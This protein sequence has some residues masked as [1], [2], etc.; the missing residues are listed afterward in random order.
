MQRNHSP[1]RALTVAVFLLVL[2]SSLHAAITVVPKPALDAAQQ[3]IVAHYAAVDP[4]NLDEARDEIAYIRSLT[5]PRE[6]FINN[7]ADDR[8][9]RF[10]LRN[11]KKA[12]RTPQ[13]APQLFATVAHQRARHKQ[14]PPL[15]AALVADPAPDDQ[16]ITL[17]T[18]ADLGAVANTPATYSTTG[19]S[20]V[21]GGT[22]STV[23]VVQLFDGSN[24]NPIGTG[25]S[26][27]QFGEGENLTTVQTSAAAQALSSV[28][29]YLQV[30]MQ[31]SVNADPVTVT[32]QTV[33]A[34][35]PVNPP[36]V[37]APIHVFQKPPNQY[38]TI[39]L[40]RKLKPDTNCDYGPFEKANANPIVQL[41]VSGSITYPAPI[42]TKRI[43]AGSLVIWGQN[44]GGACKVTLTPGAFAQAFTP[45]GNQLTWSFNNANFGLLNYNP[46]WQAGQPYGMMLDVYVPLVGTLPFQQFFV[47]TVPGP[48]LPNAKRIDPLT[49]TF[50]CFA[51]GTRVLMADG[52]IKAIEDIKAGD[53]VIADG[54]GRRLTVRETT[55]GLEF[56]PMVVIT[57]AAGHTLSITE[58]HAVVIQD[59]SRTR[60]VLAKELK[61]GDV[62]FTSDM[63]LENGR[64]R[65][66][67]PSRIV[68]I[69]RRKDDRHVYNV[70]LGV[71]E[72]G[73]RFGT[74][75]T[76]LIAD[77]I[78][79][80]DNAM[81]E[82]YGAAFNFKPK[83]VKTFL[84]R[85]WHRDYENH[86][87]EQKRRANTAGGK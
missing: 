17:N 71:R 21:P 32:V 65:N 15:S 79:T 75:D 68:K 20:T 84:P 59:G 78:L 34:V 62:V 44:G 55:A 85:E 38:I 49:F 39:C 52:S 36:D 81:Q 28:G 16:R 45:N 64:P 30:T 61:A 51:A 7:L 1:I 13:N 43:I 33:A 48:V 6:Q 70:Y 2:S 5:T 58:G 42:D 9:L 37:T 60:V 74:T 63:A 87:Q 18:I 31:E 10:T 80:G 35:G 54:S 56:P 67:K 12:G 50:G 77:G 83:N 69:D 19:L 14:S 66:F 41:P 27:Q 23:A 24:N 46:C 40:S 47:T 29:S 72:N 26:T 22:I 86:L 82:F 8:Q 4:A 11:L 25:A 53:V 57:D 3:E 73:E 76:T